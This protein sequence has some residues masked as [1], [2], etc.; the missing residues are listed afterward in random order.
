MVQ[1]RAENWISVDTLDETGAAQ[2]LERLAREIAAHDVLYY[3]EDAP[4]I[5]DA[6]YDALRRRNEILEAKFPDLVRPDSPSLRVGATPIEGFGKVSH[7]VAMLSLDNV[8]D[9]DGMAAFIDRVRR[10]MGFPEEK[11]VEVA[12]EPKIDGLSA[13]LRYEAGVFILGATRGDGQVGENITANLRTVKTIPERLEGESVPDVVEVRGEVYMGRAD[14]ERLNAEREKEGEDLFANLRNAAAGSLR[15]LDSSITARRPLGF[16][17]YG[18]GEIS[19]VLWQSQQEIQDSLRGWGFVTP[20]YSRLCSGMKDMSGLYDELRVARPDLDFDIDGI[21][22]K[23]NCLDWQIRLGTVSRA[24]RWAVARKFPAE[25]SITILKSIDIQVGRTGTLT[26]VAK[27]EPVNV[28]GVIVS[29][30]TLHNEDE[31]TRKDIR[32][33]DKVVIQRAGDVI[34]QVVEV[35]KDKRRGKTRRFAFPECCPVCD[36]RAV[37]EEDETGVLG[38]VRRCEGGL[39][40]PAQAEARLRHFVSRNAFDIEG[41]GNKQIAAFFKDGLIKRPDDI[42]TLVAHDEKSKAKFASREGWGELSVSNLFVAI[43]ARRKISLER[44]LFALGIRHIGEMMARR[45]AR[46]FGSLE[47]LEAVMDAIVGSFN[48]KTGEAWERLMS[49]EGIG[50]RVARAVVV[51][52]EEAHNR[53]VLKGLKEAG[54]MPQTVAKVESDATS[55]LAGQTIVFTGALEHQTRLEAKV[56]AEMLGA[57]VSSA[58]SKRIDIVV[59]GEGSGSKRKKAQE[60][61]LR[62]ID[63][64]KWIALS[65]RT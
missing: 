42:F 17:A 47:A 33:G 22:Y 11:V 53:D 21:V 14:F 45:I 56:C 6:A 40:C 38:A 27:L 37:R 49:I 9:E 35:L 26:P 62:I 41:L 19:E 39:V 51:F 8:F 15:Q 31:I 63:E 43:E 44:F 60:L 65:Q 5:S 28:S 54:V 34:P 3:Q 61:G 10:F 2:E 55:P 18:L 57:E 58:V 16:F 4:V 48:K 46:H 25:Q 13:S 50:E 29:N 36:S 30:A 12:A 7:E 24:P 59:A 52:F 64:A 20:P 32:V 1:K 23:V